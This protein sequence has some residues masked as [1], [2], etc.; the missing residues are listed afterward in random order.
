MFN[1]S[2]APSDAGEQTAAGGDRV[3]RKALGVRLTAL[4]PKL[5]ADRTAHAVMV[6]AARDAV[7]EAGLKTQHRREVHDDLRLGLEDEESFVVVVAAGDRH[8]AVGATTA[9]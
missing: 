2:P 8:R 3:R 6:V 7:A 5:Y 9:S 4:S 1:P